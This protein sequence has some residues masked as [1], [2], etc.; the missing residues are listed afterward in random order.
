MIERRHRLV[1]LRAGVGEERGEL[2]DLRPHL[3]RGLHQIERRHDR[4]AEVGQALVARRREIE[5]PAAA[6]ADNR[7]GDDIEQQLH[8]ARAPR[9]R[10]LHAH[11]DPGI[12]GVPEREG[13]DTRNSRLRRAMPVH[14]AVRRGHPNRTT[15][16][17]ADL[18][19]RHARSERGRTPTRAA[20]RRARQIPRVVGPSVDD[21]VGLPIGHRLRDVR[22]AQADMRRQRRRSARSAR[23]AWAG[24]PSAPRCLR[25]AGGRRRASTPSASSATPAEPPAH[26]QRVRHRPAERLRAPGRVSGSRSRSVR[27]RASRSAE[28]AVRRARRS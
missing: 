19:R 5:P 22:L 15:D 25:T 27:G 7:S 9:Q 16:V 2:I 20:A 6:L 3:Q 1:D 14:A 17:A 21:A 26:P 8:V 11:Q 18:E 4:D 28:G 10:T 24:S 12:R 23:P 13:T